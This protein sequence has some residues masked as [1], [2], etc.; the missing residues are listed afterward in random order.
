MIIKLL[1]N[2]TVYEDIADQYI[3][4]IELGVIKEGEKLP[5]CRQLAMDLGVNPNTVSHAYAILEEKGYV[6]SFEKRGVYVKEGNALQN[7][8]ILE[9][10]EQIQK[11][12]NSGL[13][14]CDLNNIVAEVYKEN[15]ND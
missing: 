7:K 9:A 1:G 2:K 12:F 4:Y 13:S 3:R 6:I 10:K 14:L 8:L 15:K 11:L 5:S